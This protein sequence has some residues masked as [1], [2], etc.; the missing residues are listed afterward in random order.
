MRIGSREI[1]P[2]HPTYIVAELGA[3]HGG[4]VAKAIQQ[5]MLA[6]EAGADAVK[7][8]KRSPEICIPPE[9][10]GEMKDTAWGR[11]TYLNYRNRL[12]FW[13]EY[14]GIGKAAGEIGIDW[15][16]S[17]WDIPSVDFMEP[18]SPIAYK[19]PSPC[20]TDDA[21]LK[22]VAATQRPVILSTG[23]S[24]PNEI[25]RALRALEGVERVVCQCTSSYPLAPSE[26]N[27]RFMDE[28]A[29]ADELVGYSGHEHGIAI[30]IA[31][32]ALG[33]CYVERHF[34]DTRDQWGTDQQIS[35]EPGEFRQMVD[36]IREVEQALGDGIKRVY[37][38]EQSA[39]KKLRRTHG[40]T[41]RPQEV[42]AAV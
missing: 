36:G 37:G 41:R 8:Q 4:S 23:M 2:G 27:L 22:A 33:A 28:L 15:F 5:M 30:S 17:A 35:L 18:F 25:A 39:M 32:V 3:N 19:I 29:R 6:K 31:A 16:T 20:L 12:E 40:G 34:T 7:F 38:S 9:Q 1:G 24:T 10:Q 21:L 11:M 42:K 26:V 13:H 14:E